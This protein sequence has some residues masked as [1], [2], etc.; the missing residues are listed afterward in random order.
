M[1][2]LQKV[3]FLC[4]CGFLGRSIMA[5]TAW[6]FS[7]SDINSLHSKPADYRIFYGKDPQQFGDLRL[8]TG[9]KPYPVAIIIHGG[10]WISKFATLQ[11]TAALSDALR[12]AGIATWNIEYRATDQNGGG[13][14]GTFEDIGN[15]ADYLR[16][17]ADQHPLDLNRIVA[18]GHS[19]GGH[20]ALWLAARH[21]LSSESVLY[22]SHPLNLSG[23]LVLGGVPDMRAFRAR[24]ESICGEDVIEKLLGGSN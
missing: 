12:D 9:S 8:P 5:Q 6:Y 16:E 1:R 19:A 20:L 3:L 17:I 18:I 4:C 10:C 13:W 24:G 15:A 14:P 23:A 22:S 11:N 2:L 21:K 7:P